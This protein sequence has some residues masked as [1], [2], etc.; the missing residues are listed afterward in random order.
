MK[1]EKAAPQKTVLV[2]RDEQLEYPISSHEWDHLKSLVENISTV[3]PIHLTLLT[4]FWGITITAFFG[5]LSLPKDVIIWGYP[6]KLLSYFICI[7]SFL[8]G[9]SCG[10]YSRMQ[11]NT[12]NTS[13]DGAILYLNTLE[14]KFGLDEISKKD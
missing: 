7:A 1:L 13:K 3:E 12:V 8:V 2:R 6:G 4:F 10:I 14:K 9:L 11:H 5:G